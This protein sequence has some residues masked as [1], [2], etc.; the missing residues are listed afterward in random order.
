MTA[1]DLGS[2]AGPAGRRVSAFWCE[3]AWLP[4]GVVARV[5]VEAGEPGADGATVTSVET[6]VDAAPGDTRLHGLVLPGI[7]NT[8]S[9]AFH[10][11]LRGRTHCGTAGSAEKGGSFWTWRDLMYRVA[12]SLTPDGYHAL[13]RATYAEMVLSG[14]T[15]V[16]EFHYLRGAAPDEM[17][18]ALVQA[19][20]QAGVRLTLL[21]ACYLEGGLTA[22]GHTPASGAQHRFVDT[23]VDAW[24][25]RAGAL[26]EGAGL[27]R[28]FAVH[29]VRAVPAAALGVVAEVAARS[30][31]P[32][33]VHLS[34]QRA[35]NDACQG[36]YGMTPTELLAENGVLGPRATAVHATHLTSADI[37]LLGGSGTSVSLCP[38]TERDLADGIGPA[39][40]LVD[41]G[42]LLHLGSDSHAV[43]DMFEEARG[44][45]AH[46][47]LASGRRGVFTP[48]ELV[49]A[50]TVNGHCALGWPD[51][52]QIAVGAAADLV[53]VRLD[54]PRTAGVDQAQ[55]V[56][57][58]NAADVTDVVVGGRVVV[59]GSQH[60]LGD[61]GRML[62]Q[63]VSRVWLDAEAGD[64]DV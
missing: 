1:A 47:R 4:G 2:A 39:R 48:A 20:R 15:A 23:G 35:E 30:R 3:H 21:D 62:T 57:A 27:R 14:V 52:G 26:P 24:A 8:H 49:D 60:V 45:E 61:V 31:A 6:G 22:E 59:A 25:E 38:T 36:F 51:G 56:M 63:A 37:A 54:S 18:D 58:A 13:A 53:A 5:R 41:A 12:G 34:E 28:G 55:L 50:M 64:T 11:A 46:E 19:A 33:H 7:A 42:S 43:I 10:R 40:A 9:H 29:S 32:L 44:A 17:D 16:G